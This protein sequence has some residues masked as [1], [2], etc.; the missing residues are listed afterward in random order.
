MFWITR[1]TGKGANNWKSSAASKMASLLKFAC[2][3][4]VLIP[5]PFLVS[6][7]YTTMLVGLVMDVNMR[8]GCKS[9]KRVMY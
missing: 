6:D 4:K 2:N 5:S 8:G 9:L 1:Q 3:S 7:I